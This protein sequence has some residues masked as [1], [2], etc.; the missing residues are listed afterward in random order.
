VSLDC[1]CG[2]GSRFDLGPFSQQWYSAHRDHHLETFPDVDEGTRRN[3]TDA[4][5]RAAP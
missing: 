2:F 1:A 5:E 4:I 3:L